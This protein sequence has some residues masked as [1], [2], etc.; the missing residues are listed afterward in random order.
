LVVILLRIE[1]MVIKRTLSVTAIPLLTQHG[2]RRGRERQTCVINSPE[3]VFA[4]IYERQKVPYS[5]MQVKT[6]NEAL[7]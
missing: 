6:K 4:Y 1:A 7:N 5:Q 2:K 3:D